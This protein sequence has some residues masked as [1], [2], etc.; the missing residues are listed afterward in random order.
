MERFYVKPFC[1]WKGFIFGLRS[2]KCLKN[3][4]DGELLLILEAKLQE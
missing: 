4:A 2:K 3:S 1:L